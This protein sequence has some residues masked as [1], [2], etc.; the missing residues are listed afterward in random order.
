MAEAAVV[1]GGRIGE[2]RRAW[3]SDVFATGLPI[4]GLAALFGGIAGSQPVMVAGIATAIGA[5]AALLPA[6]RE[7]LSSTARF[8]YVWDRSRGAALTAAA[9]AV[10]LLAGVGLEQRTT[11]ASLTVEKDREL[12]EMRATSVAK[13]AVGMWRSTGE[14]PMMHEAAGPFTVS[15]HLHSDGVVYTVAAPGDSQRF[16][17][18]LQGGTGTLYWNV[19]SDRV[20]ARILTGDVKEVSPDSITIEDERGKSHILVAAVKV[21]DPNIKRDERVIAVTN[22]EMTQWMSVV[23]LE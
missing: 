3:L 20:E 19:S 23:M 15:T 4:G 5:T 6:H 21:P 14:Y 11:V 2:R 8:A 12:I 10:V 17:A 22:P 7:R 9:A 1:T 13:T 16:L 18:D